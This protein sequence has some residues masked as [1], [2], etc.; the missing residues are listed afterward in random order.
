MPLIG[1][2]SV[3]KAAVYS[4]IQGYRAALADKPVLVSGVYPGP[5][6]TDM[7]KEFEMDKASPEDVAKAIADGVESG[8]ETIFSDPFAQ[9]QVKA[10]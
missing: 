8:Q 10:T 1:T 3:S 2:Y 9:Q 5:I 4:A 6:D 7:A